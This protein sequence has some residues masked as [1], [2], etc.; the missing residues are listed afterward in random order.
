[1]VKNGQATV[2]E[3]SLAHRAFLWS[4]FLHI[5][6]YSCFICICVV[7]PFY[8]IAGAVYLLLFVPEPAASSCLWLPQS[9]LPIRRPHHQLAEN[10]WEHTQHSGP[11]QIRCFINIFFRCAFHQP[12]RSYA[13]HRSHRPHRI[14]VASIVYQLLLME[15]KILCGFCGFFHHKIHNPLKAYTSP[16]LETKP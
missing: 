3:L 6:P 11:I 14:I 15:W 16:E 13:S 8:S 5:S 4:P 7:L 9:P 10:N 1:M 12:L 2:R